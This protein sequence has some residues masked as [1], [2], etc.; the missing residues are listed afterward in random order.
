MSLTAAI[1]CLALNI[2][3]EA[4]SEPLEGQLAVAW[5]TLNRVEDPQF[6]DNICDVV[7]QKHQ[8]SWT[9]TQARTMHEADA[10][11][12]AEII[13]TLFVTGNIYIDPTNGATYYHADYV[14]P[15]WSRKF[16]HTA[17]IG[18]HIFYKP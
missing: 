17:T 5:V 6:P 18:S 10:K 9:D 14:S 7:Y 15:R 3:H 12:Q 13:A 1:T 8:F 2:Y 11:R 16:E 4:R